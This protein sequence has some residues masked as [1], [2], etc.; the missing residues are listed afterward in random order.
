MVCIKELGLL[1]NKDT[2]KKLVFWCT[3]FE[4][5]YKG[6]KEKTKKSGQYTL[7]ILWSET[8]VVS[9]NWVYS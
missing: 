7:K 4:N 6:T 3:L 8:Q 5:N 9:R 1:V 2:K